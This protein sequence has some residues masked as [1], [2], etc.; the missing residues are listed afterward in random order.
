MN[1]KKK[2]RPYLQNKQRKRVGDLA[3]VVEHLPSKHEALSSN[4]ST[5]KIIKKLY[6]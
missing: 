1:N 5:E 2:P 4:S 6:F 3:Y